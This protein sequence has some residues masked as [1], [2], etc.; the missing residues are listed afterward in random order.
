VSLIVQDLTKLYGTQK[1]LNQLSFRLEPGEVVGFLGPNGAGKT[2]TMR[3]LIGYLAQDSGTVELDGLT[4]E[5]NSLEMRR[6]IGYLPEHN[7]L[8]LDMYLREFLTFAG[9]LQGMRSAPLKKRISEVVELTGLGPEQHKKIGMLS[10]GY[11]QRVGL[12]Q[13]ILHNPDLLILDEPTSGLDPNQV[14]EIRRLIQTIGEKKT[15]LFSSHIMS[16]VEAISRRV[17]LINRGEL[18]ADTTLEGLQA[19]YPGQK[20][21]EIFRT[22]TGVEAVTAE[23]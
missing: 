9:E 23:A 19:E 6:R 10:K 8:Y 17:I 5:R 3:I 7:P 1:A 13:A 14:L 16:E 12:A 2:T 18:K 21:E 20:L 4:H 11:R 22:L 15:V